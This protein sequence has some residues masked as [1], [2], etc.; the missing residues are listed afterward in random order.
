MNPRFSLIFFLPLAFT[1]SCRQNKDSDPTPKFD[2]AIA[3]EVIAEFIDDDIEKIVLSQVFNFYLTR[4]GG[5]SADSKTHEVNNPYEFRTGCAVKTTTNDNTRVIIDYG[6]GC[7]D[8]KGRVRAGKI[9]GDLY[10]RGGSVFGRIEISLENYQYESV[11]VT[12]NRTIIAN[13]ETSRQYA[14]I[15]SSIPNGVLTFD[16]GSTYQYN[17][18]RA[19]EWHFTST[20]ENEF[21]FQLELSKSGL[22]RNNT[23]FQ[24]TSQSVLT[25]LSSAFESGFG[26]FSSGILR[27]TN[28]EIVKSIEFK[29]STIVS[30]SENGFEPFLID[31]NGLFINR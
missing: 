7:R 2:D 15:T 27:L 9:I 13:T 17:S 21:Y 31:L 8:D 28:S 19:I 1:F 26:Q 22:D 25:S 30:V 29:K 12:G 3:T 14:E 24:S 6:A 23:H 5:V 10:E 4:P 11:Q 16:D 18:Q 20:A